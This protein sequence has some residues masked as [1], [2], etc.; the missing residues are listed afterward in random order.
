MSIALFQE[1]YLDGEPDPL[2]PLSLMTPV[3]ELRYGNRLLYRALS[4]AVGEP[5][6]LIVPRRF[7]RYVRGRYPG[8]AT[9]LEDLRGRIV[10]LNAGIR[11]GRAPEALRLLR[12]EGRPVVDGGRLVAAEVDAGSIDDGYLSR[13]WSGTEV[14]AL[15]KGPWELVEALDSWGGG[16]GGV[17]YGSNVRLEEPVVI[18]TSGGPVLIADDARVE[19]FSR[20]E[21][22]AYIGRG[23]IVHSAR[24]NHHTYIGDMCR[25]GGEVEHSIIAG[26][27]NKA[28]L[29]YLGHSYV[30]QWVNVGAGGITSDLKNTYGTVRYGR[31]RLETGLVKVGA[32]IGD[33]VKLAI[34]AMTYAGKSIGA[35]SHVYGLVDVDVPPFV[36]YSSSGSP[37]TEE[38]ELEKAMEV[39]ER[40]MSRRGVTLTD[41]VRE[42]FRG[43]FEVSSVERRGF[44]SSGRGTK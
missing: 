13:E 6:A 1:D 22:P 30:G 3:H 39:A 44:L 5:E 4:E 27:S 34:G 17:V 19:A 8:K 10:L 43:A 16:G 26:Y 18:D 28:H 25:V 21:G 11:P 41:D 35:A 12:S 20:I 42:I 15:M 40:M 9:R 33:H 37:R 14:D 23:T 29:G 32:F 24:I 31:R 7:E 2:S 36:I 38:L